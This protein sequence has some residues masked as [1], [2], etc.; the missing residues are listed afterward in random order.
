MGKK[1]SNIQIQA[2]T[3][4]AIRIANKIQKIIKD[5]YKVFDG[6]KYTPT[7]VEGIEIFHYD[8]YAAIFYAYTCPTHGDSRM[9]LF[10]GDP[11]YSEGIHLTIKEFNSEFED[12]KV[13]KPTGM[14]IV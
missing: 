3:K 13:Y 1:I 5:E 4:N 10:N 6:D 9:L 2:R 14:K 12:W 7:L 11:K 8:G